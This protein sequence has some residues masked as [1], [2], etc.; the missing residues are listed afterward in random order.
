MA[1]T[2]AFHSHFFFG[3]EAFWPGKQHRKVHSLYC[4]PKYLSLKDKFWSSFLSPQP[5]PQMAAAVSGS[6]MGDPKANGTFSQGLN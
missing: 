3:R 2:A 5:H 6:R 1:A 4:L